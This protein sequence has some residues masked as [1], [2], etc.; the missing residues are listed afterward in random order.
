MI[1]FNLSNA[2]KELKLDFEV[3]KLIDEFFRVSDEDRIKKMNEQ[4]VSFK[5]E[6]KNIG[7]EIRNFISN[8]LFNFFQT[9]QMDNFSIYLG[10]PKYK[11]GISFNFKIQGLTKFVSILFI[12]YV[13]LFLIMDKLII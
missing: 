11:N 7:N 2:L 12:N 13:F 10:F 3:K 8:E 4:F 1:V 5:N 9:I 6:Y